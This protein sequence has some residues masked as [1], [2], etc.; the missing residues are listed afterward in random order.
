[1]RVLI[2]GAGLGGLALAA[3][4][5]SCGIEYVIVE[6]HSDWLREGYSLGLWNNGRAML[7]KLGLS[8]MLDEHEITFQRFLICDGNGAI[9]REY[10]LSRFYAEFG[11]GYSHVR[12]A[13][14]HDWLLRNVKHPIRMNTS[15]IA[16][17]NSMTNVEATFSDGGREV[18]D[19]VV[20]ADGIHSDVRSMCFE[21]HL[22]SYT[23]WR[24]WYVWVRRSFAQPRTVSEYVAPNEFAAV[25]DEGDKALAVLVARTDHS[26]WDAPENRIERLKALFK[27][28]PV[29]IPE[30]LNGATAEN[31]LPVD[32]VEISL[33]KWSVGRV[34]LIGDAAHGFEPFA[35]LGGS[36]AMEDAYV[37][38]GELKKAPDASE[39]A[40]SRALEAYEAKRRRRV[41]EARTLTNRMQGWATIRSPLLRKIVNRCVPFLP[42]SWITDNYFSFMREEI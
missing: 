7:K 39:G 22:E 5:D 26:L 40:I 16:L 41:E 34:V 21:R 4:L 28:E 11:M 17:N 15:L 8:E 27:G 36:L 10:N 13:D 20:G 37:L 32:L 35:G 1:M 19:L 38:A 25:F 24:A 3:F 12:R 31:I 23:N 9:L 14:L 33:K 42:E 30:I 18:F 6:K 29:L 2:V